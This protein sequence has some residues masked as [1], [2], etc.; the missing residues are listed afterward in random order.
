M[1]D[2]HDL[3]ATLVVSL[4][5]GQN[6]VRLT[7]YDHTF[8]TDEGLTNLCSLKFSQSNRMPDPKDRERIVTTTTT[9]T[10]SMAREM[11]RTICTMFLESRL[12]EAVNG[13]TDFSSKD[14]VWE[15]TPKGLNILTRFVQRHGINARPVNAA[16]DSPR[17]VMNLLIL[18][19]DEET[20]VVID[21]AAMV[22][23]LFRRFVGDSGPRTKSG[24]SSSDSDSEYLTGTVGVRMHEGKSKKG[25]KKKPWVFDGKAGF[26]WLM[27]CTTT[28]DKREA[29]D[30]ANSFIRNGLIELHTGSD[31]SQNSAAARFSASRHVNYAITKRGMQVAGWAEAASSSPPASSNGE[32]SSSRTA[33]APGRDSNTNRMTVILR[34]PALRLLFREYL[35]ETHCEENMAFYLEVGTFLNEYRQAKSGS[36]HPRIDTVR[37]T[38]ASAYSLYNAFLAPGSPCEL[39]IDHNLRNALA[40]RMTRAVGEDDQMI[41]T[42][43]EVA[44][45]FEQAQ[46]SVFKLMAS[47]S[48]ADNVSPR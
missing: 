34:D 38:L 16:L 25:D 39:N 42:L 37:D 24:S 43:D 27:D 47:V 17:N 35:R 26:D 18:E 30:I 31:S 44:V 45:L 36:G 40:A 8:T 5:L 14:T 7:R 23:V 20:D 29:F 1:Q 2:L 48:E 11:A 46:T 19:R 33:A 9:T 13:R 28:V 15:L 6:R 41:A 3:F 22:D 32:A 12:I 21:D 10:F 4:P